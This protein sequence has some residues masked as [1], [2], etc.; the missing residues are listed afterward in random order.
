MA[1]LAAAGVLGVFSLASSLAVWPA[2]VATAL[3]VRARRALVLAVAAIGAILWAVFLIGYQTPKN[4]APPNLAPNEWL[5]YL[6]SILG[7]PFSDDVGT[8]RIWGAAGLALV[9]GGGI[10]ASRRAAPERL[11]AGRRPGKQR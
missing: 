6:F 1:S 4:H 8:A 2:L 5:P 11:A 9:V 7:L 3:W 10:V